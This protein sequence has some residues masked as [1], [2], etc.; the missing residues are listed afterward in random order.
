MEWGAAAPSGRRD[1]AISGGVS[2]TSQECSAAVTQTSVPGTELRGTG[3]EAPRRLLLM[4][5]RPEFR[6]TSPSHTVALI[7]HTSIRTIPA[8]LRG[9]LQR[10]GRGR[11]VRPTNADRI[12]DQ[13]LTSRD[14]GGSWRRVRTLARTRSFVVDGRRCI[15]TRWYSLRGRRVLEYWR[16]DG[17]AHAWSGGRTPGSYID[18]NGPEATEI[19]TSF[20]RQHRL[21]YPTNG[22]D[23]RAFE[24]DFG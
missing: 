13:W 9:V 1:L 6:P 24:D 5:H 22:P 3:T 14:D 2:G 15:R 19:M 11:L 10:I 21:P 20:F 16:V 7:K 23:G 18:P 12:V 4:R 17:L 8:G